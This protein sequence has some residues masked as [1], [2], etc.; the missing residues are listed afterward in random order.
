MTVDTE[1]LKLLLEV[2]PSIPQELVMSLHSLLAQLEVSPR[3]ALFQ[4][5]TLGGL[6]SDLEH[7]PIAHMSLGAV[8]FEGAVG[9]CQNPHLSLEHLHQLINTLSA[10]VAEPGKEEPREEVVAEEQPRFSR[11]PRVFSSVE[12][13]QLLE[14][15]AQKLRASP[16]YELIQDVSLEEFW[17]HDLPSAPFEAS[18]TLKQFVELPKD[19][20]LKKRSMN[21]GKIEAILHAVQNALLD[22]PP[23]GVKETLME[24]APDH[25]PPP[26]R[27]RIPR[28]KV[29]FKHDGEVQPHLE[30]L[31]DGLEERI[32]HEDDGP[33]WSVLRVLVERIGRKDLLALLLAED[34]EEETV[35]YLLMEDLAELQH[36]IERSCEEVRR[37]IAREATTLLTG[38]EMALS[39]AGASREYLIDPYM[40]KREDVVEFAL[41]RLF[42]RVLG[43][44]EI[45]VPGLEQRERFWTSSLDRIEALLSYILARLPLPAQEMERLLHHLFPL[46][47]PLQQGFLISARAHLDQEHG[48]W[49][50]TTG[51]Q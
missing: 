30:L 23:T 27:S 31:V 45:M 19:V 50:A 21:D 11:R 28:L 10:L 18:L 17:A 20:L 6:L 33:L 44:T 16:R 36:R 48:L 34:L 14:K 3:F 25:S 8:C 38:W 51:G 32:S 42:L 46:L 41:Y 22:S 39:G 1:Q 40:S 13:V 15:A 29:R 47:S 4:H 24:R 2:K 49:I 12:A 37:I 43:V 26:E 5:L 7:S 9:L 35:S